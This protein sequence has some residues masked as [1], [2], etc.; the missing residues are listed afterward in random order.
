MPKYSYLLLKYV[1][2]PVRD[3]S[4][5]VGLLMYSPHGGGMKFG[6][7]DQSLNSLKSIFPDFA[8]YAL[9]R[10]LALISDSFKK[11]AN[12]LDLSPDCIEELAYSVLQQ[13]E[14]S[15]RWAKG[16]SGVSKDIDKTFDD[17][18]ARFVEQKKPQK[19]HKS[20]RD[21]EVW[22]TF[23]MELKQRNLLSYFQPRTVDFG[24]AEEK[25][26]HT[27]KNGELHC[28]MPLSLDYG[29]E[30]DI[31][32]RVYLEKGKSEFLNEAARKTGM[33]VYYLVGRPKKSSLDKEFRVAQKILNSIDN[34]KVFLEDNPSKLSK[35]LEANVD[36]HD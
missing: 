27:Y 9:K 19:S 21:K 36:L 14:S 13:D 22:H 15:L 34:A 3:E 11:Y 33:K 25:F 23:Q 31:R 5:N 32:K 17:L 12:Q 16:G 24:G 26:A 8:T 6:Y 18:M 1:H 4:V 29:S 20:R 30:N 7:R 2:D 35:Y 28:L 10:Y